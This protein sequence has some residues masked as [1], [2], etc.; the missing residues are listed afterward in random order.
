ME[1]I[2]KKDDRIFEFKAGIFKVLGDANRVKILE[3]LREGEKCQC[4]IIP[5]LNQSQP[6]V[7]RHL[8]LLKDAGLI[9]F[10]REGNR[11]VYHVVDERIFNIVDSL[12]DELVR[13][14]SHRVVSKK[15]PFH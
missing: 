2:E 7:S 15:S 13:S 8:S 6:T 4:E 9:D 12:D 1:L 14:L 3:F 10:R 11:T 5:I